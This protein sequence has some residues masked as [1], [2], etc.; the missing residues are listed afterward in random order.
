MET[1]RFQSCLKARSDDK[2]ETC[3]INVT[4]VKQYFKCVCVFFY[5]RT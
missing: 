2:K 1:L 5:F 3:T 4:R